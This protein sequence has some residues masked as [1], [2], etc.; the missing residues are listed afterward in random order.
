MI[1]V[2]GRT[3]IIVNKMGE[4]PYQMEDISVQNGLVYLTLVGSQDGKKLRLR[5]IAKLDNG[6]FVLARHRSRPDRPESIAPSEDTLVRTWRREKQEV[7][8]PRPAPES[9]S[10]PDPKNSD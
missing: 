7:T 8:D 5:A 10:V 9:S 4:H 1:A 3:I 6:L 2:K